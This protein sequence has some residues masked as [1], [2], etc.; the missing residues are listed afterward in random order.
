MF[1]VPHEQLIVEVYYCECFIC[2]FKVCLFLDLFPMESSHGH[3]VPLVVL[4][5]YLAARVVQ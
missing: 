1:S 4:S 2:L 3:F 5:S